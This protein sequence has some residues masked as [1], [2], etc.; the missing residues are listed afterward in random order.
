MVAVTNYMPSQSVRLQLELRGAGDG[1]DDE[2]VISQRVN[3]FV[4]G[5]Q[6]KNAKFTIGDIPDGEY[7]LKVESLKQDFFFE[8]TIELLYRNKQNTI[9]IQMDKPVY[10]PGDKIR[11]RVIVVDRETRPVKNLKHIQVELNDEEENSIRRWPFGQLYNGV[12]ET[13]VQI[14]SDPTLG[15]W[16]LSV[17]AGENTA[18]KII[19]VKEYI[20]PKFYLKAYAPETLLIENKNVKL[21]IEATYTFGKPVDGTAK[22]DLCLQEECKKPD[23]TT[24]ADI[25]GSTTVEFTLNEELELDDEMTY[26]DIYANITVMETFTNRTVNIVQ[27]IRVYQF[28]YDITLEKHEPLI[29]PGFSYSFEVLVRDWFGKPVSDG[30]QIDVELHFE[31]KDFERKNEVTK[32]LD[33]RGKALITL[34]PPSAANLLTVKTTFK[35]RN[36]DPS[37]ISTASSKSEQY[38]RVTLN[39]KFRVRVNKKVQFEVT[40]T[41][42]MTM[43]S[44]VIVS[45]G[46]IVD[47]N[48]INNV[49]AKKKQFYVDLLPSMV[50]KA[51]IIVSYISGGYLLFDE[52]ELIFEN[53]NNNFQFLTDYEQYEPGQDIDLWTNATRDSYITFQAIDQSALLLGNEGHDITKEDLLKDLD[54]YEATEENEFDPFK[55]MGLFVKTTAAVDFAYSRNSLNR[56]GQFFKRKMNV[57][58]IRTQFPESWLWINYTMDGRTDSKSIRDTVPDTITSWFISGFALSPTLG[59]G[60]MNQPT[61]ITV[62]QPFYIVANLPYS[63][64]RDEVALIQVTVF[65]FLGNNLTTDVTLYSKQG[66]IEFVDKSDDDETRR[67]KAVISPTNNGKPAYFLIKAKKIGEIAIK[68]EATNLLSSDSL[69]HMLRVTPESHMHERNLAR[70]VELDNRG[71]QEFEL[72]ASIPK[73]IDDGSAKIMFTLDADIFGQAIKNLDSLIR[74]PTGCGEQSMVNFV[75]NA[76]ILDYLSETGTINEEVKMKAINF[77]S[78]GYQNQLKYKRSDGSFSV[79]GGSDAQG[80]TFLTAFVAKSFKIADKYINIDKSLVMDAFRWLAGIQKPDGRFDEVGR[81]IHSDMQGGLRTSSYALTSFVLIAFLEVADARAQHKQVVSRTLTYLANNL[82]NIEDVYD[83]SMATYAL[84]LGTHKSRKLFMDK[85]VEKAKFD[86]ATSTRYWDRSPVEIEVAGYALLSYIQAGLLADASSI[87]KWLNTQ[88]YGLGGFP[89]TQDTFVGLKALAKYAA[90][91]SAHKNDYRVII[92]HEPNKRY[93]FDVDKRRSFVTQVQEL[94]GNVRNYHV[95]VEGIGHGFFQ[96]A[97]QY[98]LNVEN[99]KPSFDLDVT[100]MNTT[101]YDVQNLHICVSYKPSQAYERSSMAIVEVF[102]PSGMLAEEDSVRD[103]YGTIRKTELRFAA[104]NVVVYFDNMG[105]E[106]NCF[107]VTSYRK[108]KVA[109]HRP[110]NVLV[111]DYY[112]RKRSAI[113]QYEGKLVELCDICEDEDCE[114]LSCQSS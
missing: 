34:D 44:Y 87:M 49:N 4:Q 35:E 79:W 92:R 78:S 63:I 112:N 90:K 45:K 58:H 64:K 36:Y 55:T 27:P 65:N 69:E 61:K 99:A 56:Q 66:E 81:M 30:N 102:F 74:L 73:D 57:I 103:F 43:F 97:Y 12:F 11:L 113:K 47:A 38:L 94:P 77:L 59:M 20:L 68:I 93:T 98:Y 1:S 51:R 10:K 89:G 100:V 107:Q 7:S 96:I 86:N 71:F 54:L 50:P 18:E 60:F 37:I 13:E 114:T 17:Q 105:T 23:Y 72:T 26:K 25:T 53:F 16:K 75:P 95:R 110:A 111:Y 109:M 33:K 21:T 5:K 24:T 41:K 3:L 67:T 91:T 31:G 15:K 82:A 101:T 22:V 52:Q 9:L 32:K 108:Y 83:L 8:E 39:P 62:K 80:S 19:H 46:K 48:A 42:A 2:N 104:T 28:P 6:A 85:L 70:F 76:V 84:H 14:A 106:K 29:R 40:C 88:R